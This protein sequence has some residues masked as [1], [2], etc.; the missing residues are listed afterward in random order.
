MGQ[1][2]VKRPSG[3][4]GVQDLEL[5]VPGIT[6][7]QETD[8]EFVGRSCRVRPS[9][10]HANP[11]G[12]GRPNNAVKVPLLPQRSGAGAEIGL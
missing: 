9:L 8:F 6:C 3:S 7:A 11:G 5:V 4:V 10:R 2:R 12:L 1:L